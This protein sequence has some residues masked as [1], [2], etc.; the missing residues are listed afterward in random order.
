MPVVLKEKAASL[1]AIIEPSEGRFV[2]SCPELDLATEGETP[3]EAVDDLV[4]MAIDYADQYA[5][6][7]ERFSK[8]PNRTGHL[9]FI[10]TIQKLHSKEKVRKL[11]T[12]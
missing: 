2:A 9:P 4:E 6:E 10:K 3:E 12:W 8:S 11:F 1:T 7:I 5:E